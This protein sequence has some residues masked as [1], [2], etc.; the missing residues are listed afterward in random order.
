M[1]TYKKKQQKVHRRKAIFNTVLCL[2]ISGSMTQTLSGS[3][4]KFDGARSALTS[5]IH[6]KQINHP[7]DGIA[8]VV[9]SD[10]AAVISPFRFPNDPKLI[11]RMNKI[12][13]GTYTNISSGLI[14]AMKLHQQRPPHFCKNI[15]LATDGYP[16]PDDTRENVLS[17]A[18]TAY[19]NRIT[20]HTVGIGSDN[21]F[22]PVFLQQV[23]AS[24]HNGR[25][26]NVTDLAGFT[27]ALIRASDL[28]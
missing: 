14:L 23:A 6:G 22:D 18:R 13:M 4:T 28:A 12:R 25:Y 1:Y 3:V 17:L 19:I 5:M 15:I 2:D 16:Y 20:I 8:I 27:N 9:F 24:T 26:W 11:H 21:T 7:R 10:N